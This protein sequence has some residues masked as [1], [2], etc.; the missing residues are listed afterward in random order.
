MR[1]ESSLVILPDM[2]GWVWR[3]KVGIGC[4]WLV[5]RSEVVYGWSGVRMDSEFTSGV[6][7]FR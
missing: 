2:V 4:S 6:M 1:E 3:L 7:C 5:V